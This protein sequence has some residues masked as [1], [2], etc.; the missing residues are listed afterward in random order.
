MTYA[1]KNLVQRNNFNH[2]KK[3]FECSTFNK[4]N[5]IKK[6]ATAKMHPHA[7]RCTRMH[8]MHQ[9]HAPNASTC[10]QK[11]KMVKYWSFSLKMFFSTTLGQIDCV[12]YHFCQHSHMNPQLNKDVILINFIKDCFSANWG[13]KDHFYCKSKYFVYA[14][15][16]THKWKIMKY[17]YLSIKLFYSN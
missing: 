11:L 5:R 2:R 16:C 1:T 10:T 12:H 7:P 17:E 8:P 9:Q 3:W 14:S 6:T 15:T 13:Y 4:K